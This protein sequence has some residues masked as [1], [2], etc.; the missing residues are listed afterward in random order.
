MDD[1]ARPVSVGPRCWSGPLTFTPSAADVDALIAAARPHPL[2]VEFLLTGEL[3]CV[4]ATFHTHA[5][6]VIAARERLAKSES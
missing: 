3:G 2:G 6:T 4:A 5:F 1:P